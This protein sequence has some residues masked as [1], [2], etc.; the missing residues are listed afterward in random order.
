MHAEIDRT[1]IKVEAE[2]A[3]GTDSNFLCLERLSVY[4]EYARQGI[5]IIEHP[6]LLEKPTGMR[7]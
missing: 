6:A 2:C 1:H 3:V 7:G 5:I 4:I